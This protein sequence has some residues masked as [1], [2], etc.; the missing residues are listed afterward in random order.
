MTAFSLRS[1]LIGTTQPERLR[2]WYRST[3]APDHIGDGPFDFGGF[4]L[5]I[6]GR[7]DIAS[8]TQESDRLILNF[9]VDDFDAVAAQLAACGVEWI[10]PPE[11]RKTGRFATFADPDGNYLQIVSL[12]H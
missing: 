11:V 4:R 3:L 1:I 9:N 12:D 5:V 7:N 2:E 6:D 8:R 10:A